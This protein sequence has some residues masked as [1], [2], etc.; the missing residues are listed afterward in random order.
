MTDTNIHTILINLIAWIFI[1]I[2]PPYILS[3]LLIKRLNLENELIK[4]LL[5]LTLVLFNNY[6]ARNFFEHIGK[7]PFIFNL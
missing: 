5:L 4:S 7:Y 3:R 6:I 1:M 2:I